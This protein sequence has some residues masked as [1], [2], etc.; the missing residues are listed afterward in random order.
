ML[1]IIELIATMSLKAH[2]IIDILNIICV[3]IAPISVAFEML[4][5]KKK[6]HLGLKD[7]CW[8]RVLVQQIK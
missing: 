4:K 1:I 8:F 2:F 5:K 3:F 6:T 7:L